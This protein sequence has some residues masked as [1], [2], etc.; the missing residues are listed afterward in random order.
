MMLQ[1][2][3]KHIYVGL[4]KMKICVLMAGVVRPTLE[5]IIQNIENNISFF[6]TNY[7]LHTFDFVICSYKNNH[8]EN[9]HNYCNVHKIQSYFLE[10]IDICDIP[11]E[12]VLPPPNNNRYR[13]F[14]SMNYVTSKIST[15][16]DCV[17]RLR[18]DTEIKS[19]ELVD[20][21][22]PHTYY[23]VIDT[24]TSC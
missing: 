16:Y 17:I 15:D 7:P 3:K 5:Q 19:F 2:P 10:P 22:Q 8:Y 6:L 24:S 23:T 13:L 11:K 4:H 20:T 9:L 1:R 18:I 21:I 14:Y 12:L